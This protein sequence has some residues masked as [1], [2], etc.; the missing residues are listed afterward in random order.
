MSWAERLY[1]EA[2]EVVCS[3]IDARSL[4]RAEILAASAARYARGMAVPPLPGSAL[5]EAGA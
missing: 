2:H 3:S 5:L 1:L 4:R